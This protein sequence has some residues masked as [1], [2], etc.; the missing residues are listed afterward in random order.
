MIE[1]AIPKNENKRLESLKKYSILDTLPEKEYDEI[2]ELASYICETPIS[3]VSLIDEERQWFKSHHGL[4]VDST[5]KNVAF[6]AHA[7]NDKNNILIIPDSRKDE[8]FHDNPLVTGDPYVIFYAG[9]PLISS[10]GY[11]LG[12][13]CVIDNKPKKLKDSQLKALRSL[14]NQL[15]RLFEAR[16]KALELDK[17]Y[18][19]LEMQNKGLEDFAHIAA[20]DIKS[21]VNNI[22]QLIDLLQKSHIDQNNHEAKEISQMISNSSTKLTKLI[23]GILDY[24][25]NSKLL[26]S[27][28]EEVN[29]TSFINEIITSYFT[30]LSEEINFKV[31]SP[32]NLSVYINKIALE[33]ILINLISNAIKYNDKETCQ[34]EIQAKEEENL[35]QFNVIDNGQG[36]KKDEL[37]KIFEIF[38]VTSNKDKN[39]L[40]GT[41]IGLATVNSLV[42]GLGG[43]I[44]VESEFGKGTN[45]EFTVKK[46]ATKL[47]RNFQ[48]VL[49]EAIDYEL[50]TYHL[51]NLFSESLDADSKFWESIAEEELNHVSALRKVQSFL[52]G[53]I[54][55][56]DKV[57]IGDVESIKRAR[58]KL[59]QLEKKFKENPTPELA[60][61]IGKEI[62]ESVV[63]K[64]YQKFSRMVTD[65]SIISLFQSLTGEEKN[66]LQR[67]QEYHNSK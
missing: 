34:I 19:E 56:K 18:Y 10:D 66:H 57:I 20:H 55:V 40:K 44:T 53:E 16:K 7:I 24:S 33:Q 36:I 64:T 52:Q 3:L 65:D 1:P 26:S 9:I 6:C 22:K 62:E 17:K 61:S 23:D 14:S 25:R 12:T 37:S 45:F 8:R 47:L 67:I 31:I 32:K 60:F 41:G 28:K 4:K 46:V 2:T 13:L 50:D 51:Y 27:E 43:E 11:P 38:E 58:V 49:N 30:N 29:L 63:E 35:I 59:Y 42:Q 39:G 5:P 15:M 48:Q 21:P 54:K